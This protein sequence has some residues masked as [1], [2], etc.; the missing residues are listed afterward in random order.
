MRLMASSML[1][2]RQHAQQRQAATTR[3]RRQATSPPRASKLGPAC[4][5]TGLLVGPTGAVVHFDVVHF[6]RV[7]ALGARDVFRVAIA[8]QEEHEVLVVVRFWLV[9]VNVVCSKVAAVDVEG[10]AWNFK[11][12]RVRVCAILCVCAQLQSSSSFTKGC[13]AVTINIQKWLLQ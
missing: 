7:G 2:A 12:A 3:R 4:I 9:V 13:E 11:R 1:D 6:T 10:A 5:C 8:R